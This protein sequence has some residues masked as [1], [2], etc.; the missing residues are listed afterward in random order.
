MMDDAKHQRRGRDVAVAQLGG[1]YP[2]RDRTMSSGSSSVTREHIAHA[3]PDGY[4]SPC[5]VHDC[6]R[7]RLAW[8]L[9]LSD[10]RSCDRAGDGRVVVGIPQVHR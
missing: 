5:V 10:Q 3:R 9:L 1:I 7:F 4:A 6:Q 2:R 8:R